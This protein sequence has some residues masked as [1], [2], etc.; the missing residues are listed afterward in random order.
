M[1]FGFG[2][3]NGIQRPLRIVERREMDS[4]KIGNGLDLLDPIAGDEPS[5]LRE[6]LE[7]SRECQDHSFE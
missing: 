2:C 1:S 7:T 3:A 5:P 6:W 4:M